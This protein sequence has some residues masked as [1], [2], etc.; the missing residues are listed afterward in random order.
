MN[1]FI[2]T[3]NQQLCQ[4]LTIALI[5][6]GLPSELFAAQKTTNKTKT[7]N[8]SKIKTVYKPAAPSK[9]L[10]TPAATPTPPNKTVIPAKTVTPTTPAAPLK[11]TPAPAPKKLMG[12]GDADSCPSTIAAC[13]DATDCEC[14]SMTDCT[15]CGTAGGAGDD[16]FCSACAC[17]YPGDPAS[18][19]TCY[20]AISP[21]VANF[22]DCLAAMVTNNSALLQNSVNNAVCSLN[23][24]WMTKAKQIIDYSTA[25]NWAQQELA[26][27]QVAGMGTNTWQQIMPNSALAIN[28]YYV[29]N[30]TSCTTDAECADETIT[31][32]QGCVTTASL[33][34][35]NSCKDANIAKNTPGT[36][37]YTGESCWTDTQCSPKVCNF[38][39]GKACSSTS[40]CLL[41][42]QDLF[43]NKVNT[44]FNGQCTLTGTACKTATAA[45]D[46]PA[47]AKGICM[48]RVGTQCHNVSTNTCNGTATTAGTCSL[49]GKICYVNS[50]CATVANSCTFANTCVNSTCLISGDQ[51]SASTP[52]PTYNNNQCSSNTATPGTCSIDGQLCCTNASCATQISCAPGG[53][54]AATRAGCTKTVGCASNPL[55]CTLSTADDKN[56]AVLNSDLV[57]A[58][59]NPLAPSADQQICMLKHAGK[60]TCYGS[61]TNSTDYF[62]C[63]ITGGLACLPNVD[64]PSDSNTMIC[65]LSPNATGGPVTPAISNSTGGCIAQSQKNPTACAPF[66]LV[67]NSQNQP[68]SAVP[69]MV[70][71]GAENFM[72]TSLANAKSG[73]F[74]LPSSQ[75]DA[76]NAAWKALNI[77]VN[78]TAS[79]MSPYSPLNPYNSGIAIVPNLTGAVY[80]G[81]TSADDD[82]DFNKMTVVCG[83]DHGPADANGGPLL[84]TLIQNVASKAQYLN[85]AVF[86][87]Q[88]YTNQNCTATPVAPQADSTQPASGQCPYAYPNNSSYYTDASNTCNTTDYCT[89]SNTCNYNQ[90]SACIYPTVPLST[91]SC[92]GAGTGSSCNLSNGV[93]TGT[94]TV[95]GTAYTNS[96]TSTS[97]ACCTAADCT[98]NYNYCDNSVGSGTGAIACVPNGTCQGGDNSN[99]TQE[100]PTGTCIG[101]ASIGCCVDS[102]CTCSNNISICTGSEQP[103]SCNAV[104]N[105]NTAS[106]YA[107]LQG[108]APLPDV[109]INCLLP[110]PTADLG[111]IPT[112]ASGSAV[113]HPFGGPCPK[114]CAGQNGAYCDAQNSTQC[115]TNTTQA[116][117]CS[118][119]GFCSVTT[120]QI[121]KVATDC[122]TGETCSSPNGSCACS[123]PNGGCSGSGSGLACTAS[124]QCPTGQVCH[125]TCSLSQPVKACTSETA[126]TD[127]PDVY[128]GIDPSNGTAGTIIMAGSCVGQPCGVTALLQQFDPAQYPGGYSDGDFNAFCCNGT[129]CAADHKCH[130]LA[131]GIAC[132]STNSDPGDCIPV[133]GTKNTPTTGL[134]CPNQLTS[135]PCDCYHMS[136]TGDSDCNVSYTKAGASAPLTYTCLNT[137]CSNPSNGIGTGVCQPNGPTVANTMPYENRSNNTGQQDPSGPGQ[138]VYDATYNAI[139]AQ[140][141]YA[142]LELLPSY[143]NQDLTIAIKWAQA[144]AGL[145]RIYTSNQ[146]LIQKTAFN[147][148]NADGSPLTCIAPGTQTTNSG[149]ACEPIG[150]YFP[151]QYTDIVDSSHNI[152]NMQ[153]YV[154]LLQSQIMGLLAG[155]KSPF[156]VTFT[157]TDAYKTVIN[158][159]QSS[160]TNGLCSYTP[161]TAAGEAA[162]TPVS[163]TCTGK[164]NSPCV[165]NAISALGLNP[166]VLAGSDFK[167]PL[168]MVELIQNSSAA[169]PSGIPTGLTI[170]P[171]PVYSALLPNPSSYTYLPTSGPLIM[172]TPGSKD[173]S[174]LDIPVNSTPANIFLNENTCAN[175][176]CDNYND[177][178]CFP[179][180]AGET[181]S[182]A[183]GTCFDPGKNLAYCSC[184]LFSNLMPPYDLPA[185]S[186]ASNTL[187]DYYQDAYSKVASISPSTFETVTNWDPVVYMNSFYNLLADYQILTALSKTVMTIGTPTATCTAVASAPPVQGMDTEALSM[188]IFGI[189]QGVYFLVFMTWQHFSQKAPKT[190]DEQAKADAKQQVKDLTKAKAK[191]DATLRKLL[192]AKEAASKDLSFKNAVAERDARKAYQKAAKA[193]AELDKQVGEKMAEATGKDPAT[194]PLADVPAA[195]RN[196]RPLEV[197]NIEL[198]VGQIAVLDSKLNA[199]IEQLKDSGIFSA[200]AMA[201]ASDVASV[202]IIE[203]IEQMSGKTEE[204]VRAELANENSELAGIVD[205][206]LESE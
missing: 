137:T 189:F 56:L 18:Q 136:C 117:T 73:A 68:N 31:N 75:P 6:T 14:S 140:V 71:P 159:V 79:P 1:K 150:L 24:A 38:P 173:L 126:T 205:E 4:L 183:S 11:A 206:A 130:Y 70:A 121:C 184:T 149:N 143:Y 47:L 100:V 165:N 190:P 170:T 39:D 78:I 92:Q 125:G 111:I 133:D 85:P 181:P 48:S 16:H 110:S 179:C 128:V 50:D 203:E 127:C 55:Q 187:Y 132:P 101:N 199:S 44:C 106:P 152:L 53:I 194:E 15:T 5:L 43:C 145:Y 21:C 61:N 142:G 108:A 166:S 57:C 115:S 64:M 63:G 94:C 196:V 201:N 164:D 178:T 135:G 146:A 91:V 124:S 155:T 160:C 103:A 99:C 177:A 114:S 86:A 158:A 35:D 33:S 144:T 41:G 162:A 109:Y 8:S 192:Q 153:A 84:P 23:G 27:L 176:C 26:K 2:K 87:S 186:G 98:C 95:S 193:R 129:Y 151:N 45:T 163:L 40:D 82:S 168:T 96:N 52:C 198:G 22:N 54:C 90:N 37:N 60:T 122:P 172:A 167:V 65:S 32:Y 139:C 185:L 66:G 171:G 62:S 67:I 147:A 131:N 105:D 157:A 188:M 174:G 49:D 17:L 28:Q 9:N 7:I 197:D 138:G 148:V 141:N 34:I 88:T 51:C 102:D 97:I 119:T 46:C 107:Y 93:N 58:P 180:A 182:S 69:A 156:D 202:A 13:S 83:P 200:E 204:E 29:N 80:C 175:Y 116:Q 42:S 76:F 123:S 30:P 154:S 10:P 195:V 120:T 59:I 72:M 25:L 12:L 89:S 74:Y 20:D 134:T 161:Y 77:G 112:E 3:I 113:A 169:K 19:G 118:A 81:I 191:E 104:G 36:C